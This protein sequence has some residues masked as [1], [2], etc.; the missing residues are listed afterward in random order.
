MWFHVQNCINSN[1]TSHLLYSSIAI[2]SFVVH[3]LLNLYKIFKKLYKIQGTNK[4]SDRNFWAYG[5]L[6]YSSICL[7]KIRSFLYNSIKILLEFSLLWG[8]GVKDVFS[9]A[10]SLLYSVI[11][12]HPFLERDHI[13]V[14]ILLLYIVWL[15]CLGMLIFFVVSF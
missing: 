13:R 15:F 8:A 1:K 5:G 6:I 3:I 7:Y 10:I 2:W 9:V 4:H 12:P 14:V 11:S